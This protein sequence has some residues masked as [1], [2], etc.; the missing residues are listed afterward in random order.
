M[1]TITLDFNQ[2]MSPDVEELNQYDR[3][4]IPR[5]ILVSDADNAETIKM[6]YETLNLTGHE[7]IFYK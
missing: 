3:I 7:V 4:M 1:K 2:A 6:I 5:D